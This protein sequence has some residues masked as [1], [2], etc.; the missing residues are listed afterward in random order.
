MARGLKLQIVAEGIETRAQADYL[1]AQQ[2]E[3][4]QGWLFAKA[5][6]AADFLAFYRA[7]QLHA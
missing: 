6:P 4:G 2:V 1:T 3:Y 7:R 5:L